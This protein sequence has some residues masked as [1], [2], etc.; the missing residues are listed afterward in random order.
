LQQTRN[1][2]DV[3]LQVA[4][5]LG[6]S[7]AGSLP[8]EKFDDLLY[9]GVRGLYD[10]GRGYVVAP[11]AEESLRKILER[12][13]YWTPEFESYD[14]FWDAL[15]K[16]GAW[17]DPTAL[18]V[19]RKALLRTSTGKF[20]FYAVALKRLSEEAV[21]RE[22]KAEAVAR[23]LG[24]HEPGDLAFLPA[25]PIAPAPE[26]G[27]FPLRLNTYRLA[28]RP[29]GGGRNQPWLLEQPAVHVRASW[30]GWVEIHPKTAE[31]L[32]V[33]SGD[34]VWVES[35]KGRI[36]L[37]AKLYAGTLPDVIHIPLFGGEGP[38]PNDLIASE[39]DLFRGFG[40][41]NTTRVRIGKA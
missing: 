25:V 32:R 11:H 9:E 18:P 36:R 12:Q 34:W 1:T 28:T 7:V 29:L 21:K 15:G 33:A 20:E 26:A 37:K 39:A 6:G 41:L 22:G 19:S 24:G 16:R 40:L 38:N 31:G 3:V 10:A 2:G 4:K 8:W 30:E 17:W 27:A 5:A 13:G 14:D 23:A 35:A